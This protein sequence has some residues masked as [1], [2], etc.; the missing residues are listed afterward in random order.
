MTTQTTEGA[1]AEAVSRFKREIRELLAATPGPLTQ[2][3]LAQVKAT[4]GRLAEQAALWGPD[5]YPDPAADDRQVRY[6]VHEEPDQTLGLYLM[7]MRRGKRTPI[8]DHRTWACI[9]AV[10]G[11][12]TNLLYQ[13][14]DEGHTPG[15]ANVKQVGQFVVQPGSPLAILPLDV[16]AVQIEDDDLIRHLHL[17]G[18][19]L[20]TLH[21]R[22]VY[23]P[24]T[25]TCEPMLIQSP[26]QVALG[27]CGQWAAMGDRLV[28]RDRWSYFDTRSAGPVLL[29]LPGV[30]GNARAFDHIIGALS[31]RF[32][33]IAL[34]YPGLADA[35]AIA[36][37]ACALI[38]SWGVSRTIIV[39]TS[40]GGY[41]GQWMAAIDPELVS[42]L[43]LINSFCD[44][45][46][47]H[48]AVELA[49]V[50]AMSGDEFKSRALVNLERL[51]PGPYRD[52]MC[53]MVRAQ[54]G[55]GLRARR[56]AVLT[57]SMTAPVK[58]DRSRITIVDSADDPI[59]TADMRSRLLGEFAGARH[60]RHETGGHSLH[61]TRRED[62]VSL[63]KS[64]HPGEA[65]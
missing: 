11:R 6:L 58:L 43:V 47:A 45:T 22:M 64:V 38:R 7:V 30:Q 44:P 13:R 51:P 50:R 4:L 10:T 40:M 36:H 61:F 29:M 28:G 20:E 57:G 25:G 12:E 26:T 1:R 56:I 46:P 53:T 27:G 54:G 62:I 24:E 32:R 18:R 48:D 63:I 31:T 15:R 37:S 49:A 21:D 59:V 23:K 2:D 17:Y 8:H 5:S 42:Q 33:V 41:V 34:G 3:S 60:V 55:S 39:G 52:Y 65:T 16:H 35:A 14:T 9:A 19:S